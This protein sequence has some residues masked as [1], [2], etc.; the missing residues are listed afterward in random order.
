MKTRVTALAL[1]LCL[2]LTACGGGEDSRGQVSFL[3]EAAA[4]T[5]G[6]PLLIVD[7]REVASW[8]YLYWLTCICDD[9]R[10]RYRSAG[11]EL[12][13]E[14][15][16]S[17]GT[18]ADYVKDQALANT[19]LYATV[20]N[21]AETY[22]CALDEADRA[23]LET[24]WEE[25]VAAQGG[26]EAYL[27]EL[28]QLGLNRERAERLNGIGLLYAKLSAL[29]RTEGSALWPEDEALAAWA[30]KKGIVTIDRILIAA[31][32]DREAARSKA[33]AVFSQLNGAE[34]QQELF[35]SL[36]LA[37]DD[38]AGPRTITVGEGALDAALEEAGKALEAGQLSGILE[39][40]EGFSIL[41]RLPPDRAAL[42]E[43][44]FDDLLQTAAEQAVVSQTQDYAEL[45]VIAFDIALEKRRGA[46][47]D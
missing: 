35:V 25:Q 9:V 19:V 6:A 13:W 30:E 39:S 10:D 23:A 42:A 40:D 2:S 26:E 44:Y 38:P 28:E 21:W 5:E 1:L 46:E 37:A 47:A 31:G 36:A 14:A 34:N 32:E 22:N 17:G 43:D 27:A 11:V 15:S 8:Q 18:L 45:D 12:D 3:E 4:V 24:T 16:V 41:R 33:E 29:C 7:G 20:E